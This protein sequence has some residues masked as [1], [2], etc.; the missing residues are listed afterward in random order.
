MFGFLVYQNAFPLPLALV[1]ALACPTFSPKITVTPVVEPVEYRRDLSSSDL[2]IMHRSET[3]QDLRLRNK[4]VAVQGLGGEEISLSG[5]VLFNIY[6]DDQQ[7]CIA[8]KA[9]ETTVKASPV[10]HV[11][12]DYA[13]DS[14]E[15]KAVLEHEAK[16]VAVLQQAHGEH[17]RGVS[18]QLRALVVKAGAFGPVPKAEIETLKAQM[19]KTVQDGIAA[20]SQTIGSD[21]QARQAAVDSEEEYR[22]IQS[23]CSGWNNK[24]STPVQA[25]H[26]R[27]VGTRRVNP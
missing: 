27:Y 9:V 15:G 10:V 13:E 14:C 19:S 1:S 2:T 4:N 20:Y 25:I 22:R 6:G 12:K 16:H 21:L 24:P 26:G 17:S 5:K 23:Q 18:E 7:A 8:I 11:A 3:P